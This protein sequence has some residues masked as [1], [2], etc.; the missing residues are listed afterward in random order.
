MAR[1]DSALIHV[2]L[3]HGNAVATALTRW[4]VT[5]EYHARDIT[6]DL[7]WPHPGANTIP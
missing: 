1:V 5:G 4:L 3:G 2:L 7:G 6:I